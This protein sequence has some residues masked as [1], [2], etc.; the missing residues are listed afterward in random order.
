MFGSSLVSFAQ[1]SLLSTCITMEILKEMKCLITFGI[2]AS[3]REYIQLREWWK[4]SYS[5]TCHDK[6]KLAL[7][8][9]H[10][11]FCSS[12]IL[13]FQVICPSLLCDLEQ[14]LLGIT[15]VYA[16]AA[17][18][19]SIKTTSLVSAKEHITCDKL[20]SWKENEVLIQCWVK[21]SCMG[22]VEHLSSS[23]DQGYI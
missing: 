1:Q 23:W 14:I 11:W 12:R 19:L 6:H 13:R 18:F 8:A 2:S 16:R 15:F 17:I 4:D 10:H 20:R 3:C 21:I 9:P 7:R 22:C 5:F